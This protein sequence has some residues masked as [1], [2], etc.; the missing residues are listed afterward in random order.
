[1]VAY[2]DR[3]LFMSPTGFLLGTKNAVDGGKVTLSTADGS[4]LSVQPDGSFE[5]RPAGTAGP[6]ETAVDGGNTLVYCPDSVHVY[7]VSVVPA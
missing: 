3:P 1:M 4:V 7:V 2:S 6:Y 5:T